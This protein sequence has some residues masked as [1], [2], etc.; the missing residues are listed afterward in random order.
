MC[1]RSNVCLA[2]VLLQIVHLKDLPFLPHLWAVNSSIF[3]ND[4]SQTEHFT[5]SSLSNNKVNVSL[6]R[7]V[8]PPKGLNK[9]MWNKCVLFSVCAEH[10]LRA[11]VFYTVQLIIIIIAQK[12]IFHNTSARSRFPYGIRFSWSPDVVVIC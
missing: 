2:K 5:F 9:Q 12:S 7:S 11:H 6:V 10:F 4:C 1:C 8:C 3:L